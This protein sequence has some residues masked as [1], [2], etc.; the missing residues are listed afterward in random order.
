MPPPPVKATKVTTTE[1]PL[2]VLV[3]RA[4]PNF[5]ANKRKVISYE[6]PRRVFT[7]DTS[8]QGAYSTVPNER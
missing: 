7:E 3:V 8:R 1:I 6:F 2:K 4:D 5:E